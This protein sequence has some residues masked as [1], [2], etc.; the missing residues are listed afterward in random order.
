MGVK[1]CPQDLDV[2]TLDSLLS[3]MYDRYQLYVEMADCG[4]S[5]A[6]RNRT[7]VIYVLSGRYELLHDPRDLYRMVSSANRT[8]FQTEPSD[9]FEAPALELAM[10]AM[11]ACRARSVEY[12]PGAASW[13]YIL[14][15]RETRVIETLN[16]MYWA[17]FRSNPER[18]GNLIYFLGDNPDFCVTWSAVSRRVPCL[19]RNIGKLWIPSRGRWMTPA[20]R[21]LGC[22][23]VLA[24]NPCCICCTC[25][26]ATCLL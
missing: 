14:N 13:H 8:L 26:C 7:Y 1:Q 15:R 12:V 21:W 5:G 9:Y 4:H 18:D 20:E 17:R 19:R 24:R 2:E 3:D 25:D 16:Q 11:D 23:C 6:S 22:M 10:E